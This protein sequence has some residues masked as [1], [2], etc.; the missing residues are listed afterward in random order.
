MLIRVAPVHPGST[1]RGHSPSPGSRT[2]HTD[3]GPTGLPT[4]GQQCASNS[5]AGREAGPLAHVRVGAAP[6]PGGSQHNSTCQ[7][8]SRAQRLGRPC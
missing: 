8:L 5:L 4:A 7:P 6:A 1:H 2:P 3:T